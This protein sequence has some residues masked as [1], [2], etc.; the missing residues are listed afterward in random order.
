MSRVTEYNKEY[1]ELAKESN[2]SWGIESFFIPKPFFDMH[3]VDD[4]FLIYNEKMQ[5]HHIYKVKT[6]TSH[7]YILRRTDVH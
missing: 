1:I 4:T 6:E 3:Q 5:A 2:Y 7:G